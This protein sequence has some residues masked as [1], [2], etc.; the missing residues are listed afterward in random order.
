LQT[1]ASN[2]FILLTVITGKQVQVP[3]IFSS[4]RHENKQKEE[5]MVDKYL[6][7]GRHFLPLSGWFKC[8]A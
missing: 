8:I 2:Y 1:S 5:N 3:G 4:I 7:N 6:L